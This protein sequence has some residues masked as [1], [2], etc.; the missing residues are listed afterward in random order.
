MVERQIK[1]PTAEQWEICR[2]HFFELSGKLSDVEGDL[3]DENV[4]ILG[5]LC[6]GM[7]AY[8]KEFFIEKSEDNIESFKD[9]VCNMIED[10]KISKKEE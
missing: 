4:D 5:M 10:I 3:S 9:F 8:F 7:L 1:F 6:I 2:K